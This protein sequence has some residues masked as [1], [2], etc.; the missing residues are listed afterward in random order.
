[1]GKN[2]I[3]T[4]AQDNSNGING[5]SIRCYNGQ[6]E[7]HYVSNYTVNPRKRNVAYLQTQLQIAQKEEAGTRLNY[8]EFDFMA[9]TGTQTDSAPVYDSDGLA[10]V[11]P[12][13]S[14]SNA[15]SKPVTSNSAHSSRESTVVKNERVIAPEIFR[16]NPFKA[17]RVD[18][19]V[20]NKHVKASV[21]TKTITV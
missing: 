21:R 15:L 16:I 10:E 4:R 9:V 11:F 19:F 6:G 8:E 14:E 18:N 7:G 20:P 17:S 5:N 3:A 13:V 1:M 2:V 12:K